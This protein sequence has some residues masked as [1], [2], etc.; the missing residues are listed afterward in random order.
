MRALE[1]LGAGEIEEG[2]PQV[3][4]AHVVIAHLSGFKSLWPAHDVGHAMRLFIRPDIF[5]PQAV[6]AHHVAVVGRIDHYGI[7]GLAGFVQEVQYRSDVMVDEGAIGPV[8]RNGLAGMLF[9]DL[10]K[11]R[12]PRPAHVGGLGGRLRRKAGRRYRNSAAPARRAS[13]I[14]PHTLWARCRDCAGR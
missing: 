10:P 9:I 14:A 5:E 4:S 1:R 12:F 7:F 8:M 2:R 13:R 3:E 6:S 11:P